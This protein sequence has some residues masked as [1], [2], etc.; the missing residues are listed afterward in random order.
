MPGG[1]WRSILRWVAVIWAGS[2]VL[3][4]VILLP[5]AWFARGQVQAARSAFDARDYTGAVTAVQRLDASAHA[6]RV[7]L[8]LPAPMSLRVVPVVGTYV[9]AADLGCSVVND[10]AAAVGSDRAYAVAEQVGRVRADGGR[11]LT[12]ALVRAGGEAL[13][14]AE[15][16]LMRGAERLADLD[17]MPLPSSLAGPVHRAASL[18]TTSRVE[19]VTALA[20]VAPKMLGFDQPRTYFVALLSNAEMRSIGGFL[21]QYAIVRFDEGKPTFLDVGANSA[22]APMATQNTKFIDGTLELIGT[23][24]PEWVNVNLSPHGPDFGVSVLRGW[25]LGTGQALDGMIALDVTTAA[26]LAAAA[27][28]TVERADGV[29]LGEAQAIADYAQN[30]VYFDFPDLASAG[31]PRKQYQVKVLQ[32]LLEHAS[33]SFMDV[34]ALASVLPGAINERRL[35]LYFADPALQKSIA[36]GPV[37]QDIRAYPGQVHVTYNNGSGNKFDWYV[38]ISGEAR[39]PAAGGVDLKVRVR[40]LADP[41]VQYPPYIGQR[42]DKPS[43]KRAS[44]FNQYLFELP[45]DGRLR[46]ATLDGQMVAP[47][48]V[49]IGGRPVVEMPFELFAGQE[50]VVRLSFTGAATAWSVQGSAPTPITCG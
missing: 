43:E 24:N 10:A 48:V 35:M 23:G 13:A 41:A 39:C 2:L 29:A 27:G 5:A 20:A 25:K 19:D 21:G 9:Q 1:T 6:C 49:R 34:D 11:T 44:T 33:T 3:A 47:R 28:E 45:M 8:A 50:R 31:D 26:R 37:A 14:D 7:A 15:P 32:K 30:G 46:W 40:A 18:W 38:D 42:L 16:Y 36:S 17:A 22:L 4:A 12:V